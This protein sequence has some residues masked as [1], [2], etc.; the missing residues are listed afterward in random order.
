MS[1]TIFEVELEPGKGTPYHP[2]ANDRTMLAN[3]ASI[4][5][6]PITQSL[7]EWLKS[8]PDEELNRLG[9]VRTMIDEREFYPRIV[10]GEFLQTQFRALVAIGLANGHEILVRSGHRVTDLRLQPEDVALTAQ[11]MVG[12][13]KDYAFDHVVMATGHN[14]PERTEVK[15]GYFVSPWPAGDLKAIAPG[16]VGILGTSLSAIDALMTVSTAHG[17]FFRDEAGQLQYAPSAGSEDLHVTMMSRKG[18]LP[19]ADFYCD[20]P[21]RPLTFCTPAAVADAIALGSSTLLDRTFDL[22]A[23]ELTACD[24]EYAAHISLSSLNADNFADAYFADR[25]R[26]DPFTWA[27]RNLAEAEHNKRSRTV[28]EW[29]YAILRMHEVIAQIVPHLDADDLKRFGKKL[30]TIFIDDYA[31]VPHLSIE[32][33]L[34]LHRAGKLDILRLGPRYKLDTDSVITGAR[35]SVEDREVWFGAFIDATGQSSL[36]VRDLPFPGLRSQGVVEAAQTLTSSGRGDLGDPTY[37]ST[38][39]LELDA[40]FRPVV[41]APLCRNLYCAAIP[42]LLHKM[43]FVQGITS[44]KEIG[45]IVSRT[46]KGDAT[47]EPTSLILV[48]A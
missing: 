11:T 36:S 10:L 44:A 45:D 20:Y 26:S 48:S 17:V 29:R 43:P 9:L 7:T 42:F 5:L 23:R 18:L 22:F 33:M 38:G 19:E 30:K 31:T 4:E 32:R 39:G 27:A 37:K 2:D 24:P 34:A 40:Q 46:I 41:T 35:V 15:P 21:Y 1:I 28:V 8:L 13:Q 25:D 14:W 47:G 16:P 12:D 3:I 6:P